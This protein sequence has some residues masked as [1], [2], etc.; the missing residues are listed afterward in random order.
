MKIEIKILSHCVKQSDL[1]EAK[2][3]VQS[4]DNV[5]RQWHR[6]CVIFSQ[7]LPHDFLGCCL[8]AFNYLLWH[9]VKMI[10]ACK[11]KQKKNS[12]LFN[13]IANKW[14][15]SFILVLV[16]NWLRQSLKGLI[17]F[18]FSHHSKKGNIIIIESEKG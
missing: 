18:E 5:K 7:F 13:C 2:K 6:H 8:L 9:I 14:K 17:K 1:E 16:S 15:F 4:C 12:F 11:T 10:A 3:W